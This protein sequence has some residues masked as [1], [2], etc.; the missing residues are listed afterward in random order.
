MLKTIDE[1]KSKD[2]NFSDVYHPERW[3][4][5][6]VRAALAIT[7]HTLPED[8]NWRIN[9]DYVPN[10]YTAF[11]LKSFFLSYLL[12]VIDSIE[13]LNR[14]R[15]VPT[16]GGMGEFTQIQDV[17][18]KLNL[19]CTYTDSH[20]LHF[21]ITAEYT[22]FP[23][24]RLIKTAEGIYKRLQHFVSKEWGLTIILQTTNEWEEDVFIKMREA[25][26][27][28]DK[29]FIKLLFQQREI[30]E[31]K[32][33]FGS[34]LKDYINR[35]DELYFA[36]LKVTLFDLSID[37]CNILKPNTTDYDILKLEH[38]ISPLIGQEDNKLL[39]EFFN[40][41]MINNFIPKTSIGFR[42][43]IKRGKKNN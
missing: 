18:L 5:I 34:K 15:I 41:P 36:F 32:S 43:F 6:F 35:E 11:K 22:N 23:F 39:N 31:F 4:D 25:G 21:Q 17:N 20:Y 37:P 9:I 33:V 16:A 3:S 24:D 26:F 28:P 8:R 42:Y 14:P 40:T 29:P 7:L 10:R 13:Y 27:L 12:S 19:R 30:E 2:H 1:Y 38:Y